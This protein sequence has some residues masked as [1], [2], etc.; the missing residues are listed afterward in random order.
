[1]TSLHLLYHFLELFVLFNIYLFLIT[2][3]EMKFNKSW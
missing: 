1:M 2:T 3:Y